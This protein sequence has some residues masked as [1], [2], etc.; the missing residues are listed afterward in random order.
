LSTVSLKLNMVRL[1]P[2]SGSFALLAVLAQPV[3]AAAARAKAPRR[4]VGGVDGFFIHLIHLESSFP[5]AA[6]L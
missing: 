3:R 1:K 6:L 4:C 2:S 5:S